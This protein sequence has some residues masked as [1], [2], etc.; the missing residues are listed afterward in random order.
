[1]S[2]TTI[3]FVVV[4]AVTAGDVLW[5]LFA[6]VHRHHVKAVAREVVARLDKRDGGN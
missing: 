2:P 5:R 3:L 4:G 6:F 1:M